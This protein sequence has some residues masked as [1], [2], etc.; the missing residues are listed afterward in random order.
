M[1]GREGDCL[2]CGVAG[3]LAQVQEEVEGWGCFEGTVDT[4]QLRM[5]VG[6]VPLSLSRVFRASQL[7][8]LPHYLT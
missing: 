4:T 1:Q 3:L 8:I 2:S 6:G 5:L 7:A